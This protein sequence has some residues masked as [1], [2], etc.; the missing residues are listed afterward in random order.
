[1]G[2]QATPYKKTNDLSKAS[3]FRRRVA[4]EYTPEQA[5]LDAGNNGKSIKE[6]E[7]ELVAWG[8]VNQGTNFSDD[9]QFTVT[10]RWDKMIGVIPT[11]RTVGFIRHPVARALR[12]LETS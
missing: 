12:L 11:K 5:V 9:P 3:D 4:L 6:I 10:E 1:M 8:K 2:Q 7:Q